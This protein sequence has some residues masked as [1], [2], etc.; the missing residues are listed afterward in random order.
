M[1]RKAA[2]AALAVCV[3][4]ST[5]FATAAIAAEPAESDAVIEFIQPNDPVEVLDPETLEEG[6]DPGDGGNV[7]GQEGPLTLDFV[8]HLDF[9]THQISPAEAVYEATTN[10]PYVQVSDRRGTGEG[11]QL[12]AQAGTFVSGEDESLNGSV[13]TFTDGDAASNLNGLAPTVQP[14]VE[15]V[16]GGDAVDV[17]TAS[18]RVEGEALNTAEGLGTWLVRWL[19]DD[20]DTTNEKV[21]LTVPEATATEGTHTSVLT[22]TLT[23]GPQ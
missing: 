23:S 2:V 14:T 12:T 7:T 11:W 8:S 1:K 18:A 5:G 17:A 22:W 6:D 13:V 21:T 9:G 19:N 15:L 16:S 20:P 3:A 10:R 4:G